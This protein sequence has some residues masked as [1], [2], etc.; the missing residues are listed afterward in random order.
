MVPYVESDPSLFIKRN[1]CF[2]CARKIPT[3]MI[4]LYV[5]SVLLHVY[6]KVQILY[7][8]PL[9]KVQILYFIYRTF[10]YSIVIVQ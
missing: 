7:H 10:I 2:A 9:I 8:I 6:M 3:Q 4:H 5:L 1:P